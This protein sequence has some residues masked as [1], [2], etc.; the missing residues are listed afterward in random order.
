MRSL[1][2]ILTAATLIMWSSFAGAQAPDPSL[3]LSF[4]FDEGNGEEAT[5]LSQYGNNG[6]LKGDPEWVDGKFEGALLFDGVGGFV[7]VPHAEILTVEEEVTVMAWINAERHDGPGGSGYQG[8]LAKGNAQRSYSLYLTAAGI[9]HFSTAGI[10]TTSLT[11][12]P[13]GEWAHVA[14]VVVGGGHIYYLNG[15]VDGVGGN[16]INLPG[17]SDTETVLVGKTHE[18][19]REFQGAIDEV[20]IWNRALD[21][22]EIEEE[23]NRGGGETPVKPQSKLATTWAQIKI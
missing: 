12:V 21:A 19:A 18:G 8:I 2:L 11:P 6:I 22:D 23:M 10:G 4:T 5:D 7:E 9:Q 17:L 1:L 20:R 3:I 16:G 13:L 14:A 15:E